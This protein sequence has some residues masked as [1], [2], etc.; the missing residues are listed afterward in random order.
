MLEALFGGIFSFVVRAVT[1]VFEKVVEFAGERLG[2]SSSRSG[3]EFINSAANKLQDIAGEISGRER[4][5]VRRPNNVDQNALEDLRVQQTQALNEYQQAQEKTAAMEI[6]TAPETFTESFLTPGEENK[7][8]YHA[9]LVTLKKACPVC[10]RQMKLQ[11][12]TVQSPQFA[13]FFWQCTGFYGGYC[14]NH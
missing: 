8:L 11:H 14:I 5:L 9:G 4:S 13:D 1:S 3:R 12:R 7:L 2:V 6:S 10:A